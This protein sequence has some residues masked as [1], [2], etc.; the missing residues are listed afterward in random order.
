MKTLASSLFDAAVSSAQKFVKEHGG[1]ILGAI[2]EAREKGLS[3]DEARN[4]VRDKAKALLKQAGVTV[5]TAV[6]NVAIETI[7]LGW[8][9]SG[10]PT[11]EV[12][13]TVA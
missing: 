12:D 8:K 5:G 4:Y 2:R 9:E 3:G 1:E 7:Y 13:K 6:L 11:G 10:Y